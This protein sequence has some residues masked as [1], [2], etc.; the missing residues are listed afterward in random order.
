MERD[1]GDIFEDPLEELSLGLADIFATLEDV[2]VVYTPATGAVLYNGSLASFSDFATNLSA[3]AIATNARL[4]SVD[5]VRR[6]YVD[7][8]RISAATAAPAHALYTASYRLAT[9]HMTRV[10]ESLKPEP[11]ADASLGVFAASI[12]LQRLKY[13]LF[14][15]HLLYQFGLV[16]EADTVARQMLEQL[17]WALTAETMDSHEQLDAINTTKTIGRLARTLPHLG[18]LY[19]QLSKSAH[20]G[21]DEHRAVFSV[22][23]S[24]RGQVGHGF[25]TRTRGA[26]VL[27]YLADAWAVVTET[28]Q[29]GHMQEYIAT[30]PREDFA[31]LPERAF[32]SEGMKLVHQLAD[33]EE[34][35]E[36]G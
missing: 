17:G 14:A 10:W 31:P 24:G 29:R 23:K 26:A 34:P 27:I 16:F 20:A 13:T 36:E 22:H 7:E 9:N 35:E 21:I 3:A 18:R 8:E 5:R 12:A 28:T 32:L 4:K 11:E 30:D 6:L 1:P 19:G 15:A 33:I 25:T 2:R